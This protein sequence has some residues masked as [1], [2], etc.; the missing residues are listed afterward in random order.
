MRTL[1]RFKATAAAFG[2][3]LLILDS[4]IALEGAADGLELCLQTV[5]PS[6][7]PFFMLSSLLTESLHGS[8]IRCLRPLGKHMGLPAGA[9]AILMVG[10]L[11]GY[12]MGAACISQAVSE[13]RISPGDAARMMAFCNNPG[14]AFIFGI[15]GMMFDTYW[16]GWL[17]WA[18]QLA[19]AIIA[20]LLVPGKSLRMSQP[21]ELKHPSLST[22]LHSSI[23]SMA[24]VCGWV[25]LFRVLLRFL[26]C[27][28]LW[29]LPAEMRILVCGLTE[30]TNGCCMLREIRDPGLRF[31][32]CSVLLSFGGLCVG[33]Q[34]N[35]VAQGVPMN[36]YFPG[37][38]LHSGISLLIAT[39]ISGLIG[40]IYGIGN[41]PILIPMSL[42]VVG[43]LVFFLTKIKNRSRI[44]CNLGV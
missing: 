26:D 37:K 1:D 18:I 39:G 16:A 34:T 30:L 13:K 44:S 40:G 9:E 17:L 24:G 11:G 20:G 28:F 5:I 35:S 19:G 32:L 29:A 14:P 23:R 8:V 15:A 21:G 10:A 43:T 41:I 4:S 3:L 12:P 31:I 42:L 6:L 22:C 36:W 7:F 33:L 25:I 38:L 27:W 2:M